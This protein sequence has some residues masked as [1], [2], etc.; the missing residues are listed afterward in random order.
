MP[1]LIIP[2]E[3]I[4]PI[5]AIMKAWV[6]LIVGLIASIAVLYESDT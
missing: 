4:E 1:E 5:L 3:A 2:S 6:V